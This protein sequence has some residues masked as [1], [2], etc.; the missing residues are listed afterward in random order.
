MGR[1]YRGELCPPFGRSFIQ[2]WPLAKLNQCKQLAHTDSLCGFSAPSFPRGIKAFHTP[3]PPLLPEE[4]QLTVSVSSSQ[5][6]TDTIKILWAAPWQARCVHRFPG[7][8][9]NKRITAHFHKW[10]YMI[11][12]I[13]SVTATEINLSWPYWLG[14]SKIIETSMVAESCLERKG[15]GTGSD[16]FLINIPE[17]PF[18]CPFS[19][20][21]WP[22][23]QHYSKSELSISGLGR[24]RFLNNIFPEHK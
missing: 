7:S 2:C 21:N 20:Y 13:S 17:L 1:S 23:R 10:L 4:I 24:E 6:M 9:V 3:Q 15:L 8:Q 14:H 22:G 11:S 16:F 5:S 19:P 18:L 12:V